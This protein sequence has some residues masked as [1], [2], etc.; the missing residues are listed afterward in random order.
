VGSGRRHGIAVLVFDEA[1]P[2]PRLVRRVLMGKGRIE[3]LRV[4][5][6]E[7]IDLVECMRPA[8]LSQT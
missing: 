1:L 3:G 2:H 5:A 8:T 4:R 7:G 6:P